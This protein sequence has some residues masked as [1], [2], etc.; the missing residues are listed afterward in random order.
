MIGAEDVDGGFSGSRVKG[1]G[2]GY[3]R[4]RGECC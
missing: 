2:K 3:G 4:V 1:S